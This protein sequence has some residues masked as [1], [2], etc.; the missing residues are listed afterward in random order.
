MLSI[1]GKTQRDYSYINKGWLSAITGLDYGSYFLLS[2]YYVLDFRDL[3]KF[4]R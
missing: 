4:K 2:L 1:K 3:V